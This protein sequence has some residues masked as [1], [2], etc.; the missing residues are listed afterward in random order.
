MRM[1]RGSTQ[2]VSTRSRTSQASRS[3][4]DGLLGDPLV[5]RLFSLTL[6]LAAVYATL[7][8]PWRSGGLVGWRSDDPFERP[9]FELLPPEYADT[10]RRELLDIP[11]SP[12][13][14][15]IEVVSDGSGVTEQEATSGI[16]QEH[17]AGLPGDSVR[18]IRTTRISEMQVLDFAE[19]QPSIIGGLNSLYLRIRYPKAARDAGIQGRVVLS[20]IVE[21]DGSTSD[22]QV[23]ES[24][25][26]LCDRA[27]VEAVAE[28]HF[29]PAVQHGRRV[30][31]RM[32]LPI[33]FVLIDDRGLGG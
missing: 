23:L 10:Q 33:R 7:Q 25:H 20:F 9:S 2:K 5:R 21:T 14:T 17:R 18:A 26:P 32:H 11:G 27:A 30:R 31:V 6:A 16:G 4:N 28:T 3:R 1:E 15:R 29:T 12:P 24:L 13:I 22:I 19:V 8:I